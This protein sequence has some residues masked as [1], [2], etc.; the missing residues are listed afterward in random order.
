MPLIMFFSAMVSADKSYLVMDSQFVST[1][2]FDD[3]NGKAKTINPSDKRPNVRCYN[4][5]QEVS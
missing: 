4:R 2:F 1:W 5:F 3:S